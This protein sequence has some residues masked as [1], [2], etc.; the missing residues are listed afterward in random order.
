MVTITV[1]EPNR[2]KDVE[3]VMTKNDSKKILNEDIVELFS[4]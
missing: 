4:P 1:Y 2:R 3:N